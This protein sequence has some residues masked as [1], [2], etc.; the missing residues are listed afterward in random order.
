MLMSDEEHFYISGIP[1]P[2]RS[3]DLTVA[4]FFLWRYLNESEC[5][6]RPDAIQE[7][8]YAIRDEIAT[9]NQGL[10]CQVFDSFMNR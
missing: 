7:L 3:P 2:V 4:A 10:L 9:I 6:N 8:N 1:W 5:R